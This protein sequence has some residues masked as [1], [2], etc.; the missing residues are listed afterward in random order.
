MARPRE[1]DEHAVLNAAMNRF[2]EHGYQ[3]TSMRDLAVE[4]GLTSPEPLQRLR[5]QT[6]AF[7]PGI[8]AVC[9]TLFPRPDRPSRGEHAAKG[10]DQ[11]F[12]HGNRRAFSERQGP[13]RMPARQLGARDCSARSGD[14]R[15]GRTPPWRGRGFFSPVR[16]RRAERGE[17]PRPIAMQRTLRGFCWPCCWVFELLRAQGPNESFSKEWRGPFWQCWT[18]PSHLKAD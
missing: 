11:G 8:G 18:G 4:T 2:W 5:R 17:H 10:R 1:F 13:A 9:A 16:D 3:A 15:R 6:R 12:H 7:S 14:R